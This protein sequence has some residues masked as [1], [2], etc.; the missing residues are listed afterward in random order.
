M[1]KKTD[2][3]FTTKK[4]NIL[5]IFSKKKKKIEEVPVEKE[6][7]TYTKPGVPYSITAKVINCTPPIP[8][9]YKLYRLYT[10]ASSNFSFN[11]TKGIYKEM[12]NTYIENKKLLDNSGFT[13]YINI[14][15]GMKIEVDPS[16]PGS[17]IVINSLNR[18]ISDWTA[19][20]RNPD[21]SIAIF[22]TNSDK[23]IDEYNV[24]IYGSLEYF[25]FYFSRYYSTNYSIIG[26]EIIKT[27]ASSNKIYKSII[28]DNTTIPG[29]SDV[30]NYMFTNEA[31]QVELDSE[32]YD[33]DLSDIINLDKS[34]VMD[35]YF[36]IIN[37]DNPGYILEQLKDF[38]GENYDI[39]FDRINH[40]FN[41]CNILIRKH[42]DIEYTYDF[43]QMKI[44]KLLEDFFVSDY[45]DGPD[46]TTI[47][48][49]EYLENNTDFNINLYNKFSVLSN[50]YKDMDSYDNVDEVIEETEIL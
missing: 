48:I 20:N 1:A 9:F 14:I 31:T 49:K 45:P 43:I 5:N 2:N 17:I 6:K 4:K 22:K 23:A 42:N 39:Y 26:S 27:I 25:K 30:V 28:F 11:K 37:A 3:P 34:L 24:L 8:T 29:M 10:D 50:F 19:Y 15:I 36:V 32:E 40:I 38:F 21:H 16:Q 12:Y 33:N 47:R 46:D 13:K 41:M 44:Y 18:F 35:N 7:S